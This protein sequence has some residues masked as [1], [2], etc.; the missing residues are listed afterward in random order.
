MKYL[1]ELKIDSI[2]DTPAS[3][4]IS[5]TGKFNHIDYLNGRVRIINED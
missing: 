4:L 1:D 5:Y 2:K 3:I